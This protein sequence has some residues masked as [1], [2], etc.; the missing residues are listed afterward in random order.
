MFLMSNLCQ[1]CVFCSLTFKIWHRFCRARSYR[2]RFSSTRNIPLSSLSQLDPPTS[3]V[4]VSRTHTHLMVCLRRI[5]PHRIV[6]SAS[7]HV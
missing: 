7:F 1:L 4:F 3:D 2:F 6:G 5:G